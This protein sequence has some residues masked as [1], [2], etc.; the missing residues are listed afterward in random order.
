MADRV[1]VEDL[2]ADQLALVRII[3]ELREAGEVPSYYELTLEMWGELPGPV[4]TGTL[5]VLTL[6]VQLEDAGWI[7]APISSPWAIRVL[8]PPPMPDFDEPYLVTP[9]GQRVLDLMGANRVAER[10]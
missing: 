4:G 8:H 9:E 7:R 5:Q 2:T 6:L 3:H 10:S 1:P